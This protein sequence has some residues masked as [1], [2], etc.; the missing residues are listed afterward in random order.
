MTKWA[1]SFPFHF[2]TTA[3]E[4]GPGRLWEGANN[5]EHFFYTSLVKLICF[6]SCVEHISH[7][8]PGS[9]NT[10]HYS[11]KSGDQNTQALVPALLF[12]D[13]MMLDNSTNLSE[14]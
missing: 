14:S 10:S 1:I 4:T 7:L 9:P 3:W 11:T 5:K 12:T 6:F 8:L 2:Y 13:L